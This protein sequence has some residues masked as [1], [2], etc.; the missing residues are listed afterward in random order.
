M[1]LHQTLFLQFSA[2]L[3]FA[4]A[5]SDYINLNKYS[6]RSIFNQNTKNMDV[7]STRIM[8]EIKDDQSI[9]Y[10]NANMWAMIGIA[11]IGTKFFFD[12]SRLFNI[13]PALLFT[14]FL[15]QYFFLILK[16]RKKTNTENPTFKEIKE[17]MHELRWDYKINKMKLK[18]FS[19]SC[20][21]K[22]EIPSDMQGK[23]DGDIKF[24]GFIDLKKEKLLSRFKE[25]ED[26]LFY[27]NDGARYELMYYKGK[28]VITKPNIFI[29]PVFTELNREF[30]AMKKMRNSLLESFVAVFV[31][32][33]TL[34]GIKLF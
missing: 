17:H 7:I 10:L 28:A 11:F 24:D 12:E 1:D 19:Q 8:M 22:L 31:L 20:K 14:Y 18:Q 27:G 15:T 30:D 23:K 13:L 33:L 16:V 3:L 21:E 9:F 25:E 32:Y 4:T 26:T 34:N 2:L 29:S 6:Q 5:I